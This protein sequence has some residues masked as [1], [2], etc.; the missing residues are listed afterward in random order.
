[1]GSTSRFIRMQADGVKTGSP[2]PLTR[3][4]LFAKAVSLDWDVHVG[5]EAVEQFTKILDPSAASVRGLIDHFYYMPDEPIAETMAARS[6]LHATAGIDPPQE[7]D[8]RLMHCWTG[9]YPA[10]VMILAMVRC[11]AEVTY[12]VRNYPLLLHK[13]TTGKGDPLAGYKIS[14]ADE[15]KIADEF[16]EQIMGEYI[17]AF[18]RPDRKNKLVAVA[19]ARRAEVMKSNSLGPEHGFWAAFD[20]ASSYGERGMLYPRLYE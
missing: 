12:L 10:G 5:A 16:A 13:C 6:H 3:P 4:K 19:L 7:D 14:V 17:P 8:L 15:M 9:G 18:P 20:P 11:L 1:M 2:G